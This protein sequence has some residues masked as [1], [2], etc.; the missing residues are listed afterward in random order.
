VFSEY[1]HDV[2]QDTNLI[3]VAHCY[4]VEL[5][6]FLCAIDCVLLINLT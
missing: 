2:Q 5:I 3:Q 6:I 1:P 4:L